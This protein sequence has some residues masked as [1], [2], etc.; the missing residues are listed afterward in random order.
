MNCRDVARRV[1]KTESHTKK[2]PQSPMKVAAVFYIVNVMILIVNISW[3]K[4]KIKEES[5]TITI[6]DVNYAF[7]KHIG[8]A[9][10]YSLNSMFSFFNINGKNR[11][12]G[13]FHIAR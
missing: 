1:R 12:I 3:V 13:V 5:H 11:A 10:A 6:G 7:E 8:A 9:T 2:P 4:I